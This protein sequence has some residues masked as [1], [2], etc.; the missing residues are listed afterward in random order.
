KINIILTHSVDKLFI[1]SK[2][3]SVSCTDKLEVGSSST[4]IFAFSDNPFAISTNCRCPILK[5]FTSSLGLTFKP[6][7]SRFFL[8]SEFVFVLSTVLKISLKDEDTDDFSFDFEV[9]SL[10]KNIFSAIVSSGNK[11]NS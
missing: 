3:V 7:R 6:T 10:P 8:H 9:N 4:N 1:I 11:F 2:R 5:F